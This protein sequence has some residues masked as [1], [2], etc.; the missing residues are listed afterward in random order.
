[1]KRVSRIANAQDKSKWLADLKKSPDR[2]RNF[3]K[4]YEENCPVNLENGK[5]PPLDI[6]SFIQY[7]KVSTYTESKQIGIMM[8][9]ERAFSYWQSVDGGSTIWPKCEEKWLQAEK[10]TELDKLP[11]KDDEGPDESKRRYWIKTDKIVE[12]GARYEKGKELQQSETPKKKMS[13]DDV[14]KRRSLL[15]KDHDEIPGQ[16]FSNSGIGRVAVGMASGSH[17]FSSDA[18][19]VGDIAGLEEAANRKEQEDAEEAQKAIEESLK[20][21]DEGSEVA[22]GHGHDEKEGAGDG[23]GGGDPTAERQNKKTKSSWWNR[24]AAISEKQSKWEQ[25]YDTTK[26]T[27]TEAKAKM[28]KAMKSPFINAPSVKCWHAT[29]QQVKKASRRVLDDQHDSQKRM[30]EYITSFSDD[31][32]AAGADAEVEVSSGSGGARAAIG[33]APPCSQYADLVALGEIHERIETMNQAED[34][35]AL[36]YIEQDLNN[37]KKPIADLIKN[38]NKR[39]ADLNRALVAAA[40]VRVPVPGAGAQPGPAPPQASGDT[41]WSSFG[42]KNPGNPLATVMA[43]KLPTTELGAQA[44]SMVPVLLSGLADVEA[45]SV[46]GGSLIKSVHAMKAGFMA[47]AK[48]ARDKGGTG[49]GLQTPQSGAAQDSIHKFVHRYTSHLDASCHLVKFLPTGGSSTE[50]P[51]QSGLAKQDEA[52]LIEAM[53]SQIFGIEK[54]SEHCGPE[55]HMLGSIRIALSGTRQVV[56][57]C[58]EGVYAFMA[59]QGCVKVALGEREGASVTGFALDDVSVYFRKMSV[60][61]MAA[62]NKKYRVFKGTISANELFFL[63]PGF[64]CAERVLDDEHA[65]GL[66]LG[67]LPIDFESQHLLELLSVRYNV[68]KQADVLGFAA[69]YISHQLGG[70]IK[71]LVAGSE[72]QK[73][74]GA[75]GGGSASAG[76]AVQTAADDRVKPGDGE[77]SSQQ[78]TPA[79]PSDLPKESAAVAVSELSPEDVSAAEPPNKRTR[80][81]AKT[82][83]TP[84]QESPKVGEAA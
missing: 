52:A 45:L 40:K 33:H 7:E 28:D 41:S 35:D 12:L 84:L 6:T 59:E 63:P 55:K 44:L 38:F 43:N 75:K 32:Q 20:D 13:E 16:D 49:R 25:W 34:K 39:L 50:V 1:M 54:G 2:L 8:H 36:W 17:A 42:E 82:P 48:V 77:E 3:L 22:E 21:D 10:D 65:V 47:D 71:D 4:Y 37:C 83:D 51:G 79:L 57:T 18:A 67:Y 29:C 70:E 68:G 24:D 19:F 23:G 26:V 62:Y 30:E 74:A 69:A 60:E 11:P 73:A 76:V 66:K 61:L 46:A 53:Q 27:L 78:Q 58:F 15:I 9:K 64:I 56:C 80:L 81:G 72:G 31:G 14:A 5:Y